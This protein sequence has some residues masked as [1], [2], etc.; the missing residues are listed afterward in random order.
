MLSEKSNQKSQEPRKLVLLVEGFI[1]FSVFSEN[2]QRVKACVC[3]SAAGS[4]TGR[5]SSMVLLGMYLF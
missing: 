3:L 5:A 4:I 1:H 2:C